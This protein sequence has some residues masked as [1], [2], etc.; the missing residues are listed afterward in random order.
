[1]PSND[2]LSD[3]RPG[4]SGTVS[5]HRECASLAAQRLMH[6]GVLKGQPVRVVRRAPTGDPIE[7]ELRHTRLSLRRAEAD[8]I[9]VDRTPDQPSA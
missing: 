2:H 8:L 1:M 6:L 9:Q 7:I 4:Q 5:G 3:L